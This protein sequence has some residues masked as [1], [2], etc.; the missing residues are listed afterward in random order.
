LQHPDS[1]PFGPG[2]A[3]G[4]YVFVQAE[5]GRIWVLVETGGHLHPKVLGEA[6]PAL[7]AGGL[8]V[9]IGG[10]V[11]EIDNFSG[12]FQF[13]A[14]VLPGVLGIAIARRAGVLDA[15]GGL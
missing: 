8:Q 10:V 2:L 14:G 9:G 3:S 4:S 1:R 7:A 15:G 11:L 13:D 6:K 5:D 12:T